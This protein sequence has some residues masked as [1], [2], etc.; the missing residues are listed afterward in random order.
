M[1][2][3]GFGAEERD[4]CVCCVR[5]VAGRV[6]E[7]GSWGW[8][9][10][11]VKAERGFDMRKQRWKK[12][13]RV[14]VVVGGGSSLACRFDASLRRGREEWSNTLQPSAVDDES[15]LGLGGSRCCS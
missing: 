3:E 11:L 8:G 6:G 14:V 15:R 9:W 4:N 5:N 7:G 10:K 13:R 2:K 12:A 1:R